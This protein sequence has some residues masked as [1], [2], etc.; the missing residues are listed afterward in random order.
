MKEHPENYPEQSKAEKATLVAQVEEFK[1]AFQGDFERLDE[2]IKV[3][4]KAL[5]QNDPE[6]IRRLHAQEMTND[7]FRSYIMTDK[8]KETIKKEKED[9]YDSDLDR[10]LYQ[11]Y[12]S[13]LRNTVV[14]KPNTLRQSKSVLREPGGSRNFEIQTSASAA[15]LDRS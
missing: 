4:V 9:Q 15:T 2:E 7:E 6:T 1:M 12:W 13:D 14:K 11:E 3:Q 10:T 5:Q 8:Q